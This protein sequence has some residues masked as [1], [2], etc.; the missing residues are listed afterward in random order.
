[1]RKPR[2]TVEQCRWLDEVDRYVREYDCRGVSL[3]QAFSD[4]H[5][6]NL[7]PLEVAPLIR[8]RLLYR[9]PIPTRERSGTGLLG[10]CFT[11]DFTERAAR[12]FWPDR[13]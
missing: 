5:D 13:A 10:D 6:G 3:R 11:V 12:H 2:L 8:M 7:S 4:V 9:L 1:M